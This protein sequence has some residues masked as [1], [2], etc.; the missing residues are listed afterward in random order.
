MPVGMKPPSVLFETPLCAEVMGAGFQRLPGS[1]VSCR[2]LIL[3]H[4]SCTSSAG[5]VSRRSS[6]GASDL[7][8]TVSLHSWHAL[9]G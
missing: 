2:G 5:R 6:T 7:G 1:M 3:A 9:P 8:L 4:T